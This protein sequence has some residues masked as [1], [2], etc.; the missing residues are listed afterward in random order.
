MD[1]FTFLLRFGCSI[2]SQVVLSKSLLLDIA[3]KAIRKI[4][5][6]YIAPGNWNSS[7]LKCL[8]WRSYRSSDK[9]GAGG[10]KPLHGTVGYYT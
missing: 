4:G 1:W 7:F 8:V 6:D 3:R 5:A 9:I 2:G 10:C